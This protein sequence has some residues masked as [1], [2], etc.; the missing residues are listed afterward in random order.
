MD[1]RAMDPGARPDVSVL[2]EDGEGGEADDMARV[3][4]RTAEVESENRSPDAA[5]AEGKTER[6]LASSASR[7]EQAQQLPTPGVEGR[8][9]EA[10]LID[11]RRFEAVARGVLEQMVR[12]VEGEVDGENAS[13]KMHL[14]PGR[15][16]DLELKLELDR[17]V[18]TARF[19]AASEEVKAMIESALPDLRRHLADQ[20]VSVNELSV[21]VGER[22]G[23]GAASDRQREGRP[24]AASPRPFGQGASLPYESAPRAT[25]VGPTG[26]D[27]VV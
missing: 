14:N 4:E 22:Q 18:L 21:L 10:G 7:L 1:G 13:L 20:G 27:V 8:S 15:L 5:S 11:A 26:V 6:G 24:F 25:Q 16:G 17:G 9:P 19:V 23:E 12:R 2:N 3:L